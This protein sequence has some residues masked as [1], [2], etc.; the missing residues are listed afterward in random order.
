[1]KVDCSD[2]KEKTP[3]KKIKKI[4]TIGLAILLMLCMN[5][6]L[7]PCATLKE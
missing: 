6:S 7:S 5:V 3:M 1:M 2:N 4:L